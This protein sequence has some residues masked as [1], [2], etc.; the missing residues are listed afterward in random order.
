[1][2]QIVVR[3]APS[4]IGYL[5]LGNARAAIVVDAHWAPIDFLR[6]QCIY[7]LCPG[8]RCINQIF[9]APSE[10]FSAIFYQNPIRN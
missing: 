5:H 9:A 8:F 4:P 1:M 3:F 10:P 7:V 2:P 6:L